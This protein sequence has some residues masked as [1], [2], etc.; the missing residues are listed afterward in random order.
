[1]WDFPAAFN[2]M[3]APWPRFHAN[4][5]NDGN[6]NT[7]VPTPVGGVSFSFARAARGLSLQWIVPDAVGGELV[8]SRAEM[9]GKTIGTFARVSKEL[10]LSEDGL[11]RWVDTAVEEGSSYVYRLESSEG[12]V[13]Y[14]TGA[15]Y[16]PVRTAS[17][18]QNYPNP[19]N[20]TTRIEYRLP[21]G[22]PGSKTAV[23]VVV[24]DVLGAKVRELVN[25]DQSAGKH[26]VDW[27]GR[28]DVG[29]TVGSGVYFYR[30][31]ASGFSAVRKMVLLK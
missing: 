7:V 12:T 17:L 4:L 18:G 6:F 1:M 23:S 10:P 25:S 15:V 13:L 2:P 3:K 20:P 16:V 29:E 27:D 30:M 19:F 28:N 9:A 22:A 8:L 24:Y 26:F 21:E 5:Y 11:V 14:E 31:T